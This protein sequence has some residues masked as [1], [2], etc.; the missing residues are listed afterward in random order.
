MEK[1][2]KMQ[3]KGKYY[4]GKYKPKNPEKYVGDI[5]N[6]IFRSSWERNFFFFKV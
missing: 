1:I 3:K 4:Q 2:V 5:N 6:I